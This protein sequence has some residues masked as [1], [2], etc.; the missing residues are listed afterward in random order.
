[1][2]DCTEV[3]I[4]KIWLHLFYSLIGNFYDK[5]DISVVWDLTGICPWSRFSKLFQMLNRLCVRLPGRQTVFLSI[6]WGCCNFSM[7]KKAWMEDPFYKQP[8]KFV[9]PIYYSFCFSLNI[10]AYFQ[11]REVYLYVSL[12]QFAQ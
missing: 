1:M 9:L 12:K 2:Q 10:V 6:S 3:M 8:T 4:I 7:S 5:N 11:K